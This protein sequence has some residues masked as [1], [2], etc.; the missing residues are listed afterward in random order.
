[1]LLMENKKME[2]AEEGVKFTPAKKGILAVA[3][4]PNARFFHNSWL[5]R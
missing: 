2:K 5:V 1:M 3:E 4:K